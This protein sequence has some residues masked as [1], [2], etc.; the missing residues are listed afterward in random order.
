MPFLAKSSVLSISSSQEF[1][2]VALD[3]FKYQAIHNPIY[4][5]YLHLLNVVPANITTIE[6]IPFL[7]IELFK[8]CDV[9]TASNKQEGVFLSSA[10]TGQVQSRHLV[11]S[12]EWY[13]QV[14]LKTFDH[15]YPD[16]KEASFFCLL[17]SYLER[18]G[19]SLV[20][21][22]DGLIKRSQ[23]PLSGFYLNN[24][25]ELSNGL[26]KALVSDHKVVLLGVTFGLLDYLDQF[27]TDLDL[28]S[29]VVMETG[30]MK[31][32]RKEL[33]RSEVHELL[34]KGFQLTKVHSEY[35][36]TELTTQAYSKGNGL[37]HC[38]PWMKVL[39]RESSDPLSLQKKSKAGGINIID[40]TNTETCAFLATSDLG[41]IY[42]DGSF[43][44]LGRFDH[45][46]VRGCN[47]LVLE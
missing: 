35:G 19:S 29:A 32:R 11:D 43:E 22:A 25:Q 39:I 21:M 44:V 6:N 45:A 14:Y 38:P 23:S 31:G 7:P 40:L 8:S 12:F 10:T 2:K 15:F 27:E 37:F 1:E 34:I 28:S 16:L 18:E 24:Y 46:D 17:P 5:K 33:L 13:E 9:T 30:G 41:K 47:L 42:P 36:M 3:L 4:K 26:K 20:V